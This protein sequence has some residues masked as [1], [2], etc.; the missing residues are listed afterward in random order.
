MYIKSKHS[1]KCHISETDKWISVKYTTVLYT[2]SCQVRNIVVQISKTAQCTDH[3][4]GSH[5]F[6]YPKITILCVPKDLHLQDLH[7]G[8]QYKN[9]ETAQHREDKRYG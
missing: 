7:V 3:W 9:L 4:H 8:L 1:S 5:L 6:H 2:T